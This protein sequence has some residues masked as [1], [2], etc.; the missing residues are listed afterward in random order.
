M[1]PFYHVNMS[2]E[3]PFSILTLT[4]I[5]IS[6]WFHLD[7]VYLY[8][9]TIVRGKHFDMPT[10]Q[11]RTMVKSHYVKIFSWEYGEMVKLFSV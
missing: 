1:V 7:M 11:E 5:Y 3:L 4:H 8:Y 6:L 2:R 10:C 9:G